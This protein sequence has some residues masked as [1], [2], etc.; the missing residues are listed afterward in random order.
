MHG[1]YIP[2][3]QLGKTGI[4]IP[5]SYTQSSYLKADTDLCIFRSAN[6]QTARNITAFQADTQPYPT[7]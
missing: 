6:I 7:V 2:K 5:Y 3:T 1:A 4:F